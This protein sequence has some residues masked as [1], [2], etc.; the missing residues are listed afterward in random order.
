MFDLPV[1]A[2]RSVFITQGVGMLI[3]IALLSRVNV[4]EFQDNARKRSLLLC[5]EI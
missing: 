1:L 2:P 3:A 5:G 4:K